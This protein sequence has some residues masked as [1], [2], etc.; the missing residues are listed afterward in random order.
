MNNEVIDLCDS[1]S[2]QDVSFL[3]LSE[4]NVSFSRKVITS[5]NENTQQS[6]NSHSAEEAGHERN[7]SQSKTLMMLSDDTLVL[8]GRDG[9]EKEE[10][11]SKSKNNKIDASDDSDS[12]SV[13][14]LID[15][16]FDNVDSKHTHAKIKS[17]DIASQTSVPSS[18]KRIHEATSHKKSSS[19]TPPNNN[20]EFIILS[21]SDDEEDLKAGRESAP[22]KKGCERKQV[23]T[24]SL[25][26][27]DDDSNILSPIKISRKK[28]SVRSPLEKNDDSKH[29]KRAVMASSKV[30]SM[31]KTNDSVPYE[32]PDLDV[33]SPG[34]FSIRNK[35]SRSGKSQE[36]SKIFDTT[37]APCTYSS[38]LYVSNRNFATLQQSAS[39]KKNILST[40]RREKLSANPIH[41]NEKVLELL[42][43]TPTVS[44]S[45][46]DSI[47]S[48]R[49]NN[50]RSSPSQ[51]RKV[52]TPALPQIDIAKIG[53]KLY[54]DLRHEFIKALLKHSKRLRSIRFQR[55]ALD[56]CIRAIVALSMYPYPIRTSY[57]AS[58]AA[59]VGDN[60]IGVLKD[61]EESCKRSPYN[62][63]TGKLSSV[64]AG[65]LV[66]LL[67]YEQ[68]GNNEKLCSMEEL[69]VRVNALVH[70]P[71][72]SKVVLPEDVAYYL[73]KNN[74]DPGWMQIKKICNSNVV[75]DRDEL[76]KE[77]KRK[78]ECQSGFVYEL[79]DT[80]RNA[81]MR[82]K[83]DLALGVAPLGPM[84]QLASDTVDEAYG[85]VTL[86]MDFREGGG[87]KTLHDMC[88][89]LNQHQIPYV[90]R[91]LKISDYVFFVGNNLAPLLI[92]RK[93]VEDVA[94][95]LSDGRWERQQRNMRKAQYVLGGGEERRC[96]ICYLIEG[97]VN[98]Q[99]VHGGY[100]GR[101]AWGKTID[102]VN[103]AIESLPSLGFSVMKTRTKE[104]SLHKISRVAREVL[105]KARN[106]SIDCNFSY[107]EFIKAV[108]IVGNEKGD[109][110]TDEKHKYPAPI[111]FDQNE[112]AEVTRD[113]CHNELVNDNKE[114][115][116]ELKKHAVATLKEMCKQRDEKMTGT[117]QDL[118]TRLLI[119]RKPE[120]LIT[121]KR[122]NQY[123]PKL[124][125]CN[126]A[127]ICALLLLDETCTKPLKKEEI[128]KM[129]EETG[130][131]KDPMF[132][133]GKSWYD[134]WSGIKEMTG[135]DP[136]LI[137]VVKRKYMLTT[138]PHGAAGI[139]VARAVHLMAHRKKLCRCGGYIQT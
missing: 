24:Y 47:G 136:P 46:R 105:W 73:D 14:D 132:G 67:N 45:W 56:T 8:G 133:N 102:D 63:P 3:S 58:T 32:D 80:G 21:S 4:T 9:M 103:R 139:D 119:P 34:P 116:I 107:D 54:P 96:D 123:V 134:G 101:R 16:S 76:I 51:N 49:S 72:Q 39:S 109:P 38:N 126:A 29:F 124:P 131:S 108:K 83:A 100:V 110:P 122:R 23:K 1:E 113:D 60:L 86:S 94:S 79:L 15:V 65:V 64:T 57:A 36:G 41:E 30:S 13:I 127:L 69:L 52:P 117:K 17:T 95:S 92:E 68:E 120:I 130:V 75:S 98:R 129:A 91:N 61:A 11:I 85:N 137:S 55:A 37:N 97:D 135:G 88:N 87:A 43:P 138:Q 6:L 99:T 115:E 70:N 111:I 22:I 93:S 26:S 44:N 31:A 82:L 84:R 77:R 27:S 71:G 40:I 121:R 106:G 128:M 5:F 66:A 10:I 19:S 112:Q 18:R 7:T 81:A 114:M 118:I 62:P 48:T 28:L 125:S 42:S 59:G 12:S 2:E 33:A 89:F 74:L 50:L 25:D 90:V 104:G 78:N 53:G 20:S 35:S